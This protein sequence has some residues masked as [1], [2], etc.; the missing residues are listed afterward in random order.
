MKDLNLIPK[1]LIVDKK[2]K[3]KKTYLSILIICIGIIVAAAYIVPT[4]YE[5]NL[6]N[7]KQELEKKVNSTNSY[8]ETVNEFNSLKKQ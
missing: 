6:R 7:N 2:N 5:N 1:S 4:I 8:V 3:V